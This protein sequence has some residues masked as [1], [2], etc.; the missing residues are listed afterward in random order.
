M[1]LATF[2]SLPL[3][4]GALN[5]RF[6]ADRGFGLLP[7]LARWTSTR[8]ACPGRKRGKMQKTTEYSF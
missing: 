6:S 5:R 3:H 4:K 7:D 8:Y 1:S 2:D